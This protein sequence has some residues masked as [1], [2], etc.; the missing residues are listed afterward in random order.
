MD[1]R[2]YQWRKVIVVDEV[3]CRLIRLK[4]VSVHQSTAADQLAI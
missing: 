1:D 4:G 2:M 3:D